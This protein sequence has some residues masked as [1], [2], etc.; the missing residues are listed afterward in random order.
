[1]TKTLGYVTEAE[2]RQTLRELYRRDPE[3]NPRT[4]LLRVFEDEL[5]PL[6]TKGRWRPSKSLV[7]S[8]WLFCAV[9][10]VFLWFTFG[11]R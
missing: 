11:A 10:I 6:D 8:A 9:I 4:V 7:L 2:T 3:I 1:M 5:R